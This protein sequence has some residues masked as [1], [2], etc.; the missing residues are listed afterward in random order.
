M[1]CFPKKK[2]FTDY[3]ISVPGN[4]NELFD[5]D[6]CLFMFGFPESEVKLT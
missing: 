4:E 5:A 2:M 6:G 3:Y 1:C